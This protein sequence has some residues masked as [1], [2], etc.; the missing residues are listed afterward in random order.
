MENKVTKELAQTFFSSLP[1]E[2]ILE[3]ARSVQKRIMSGDK[4][5][6]KEKND[7]TIVTEADIRIEQMIIDCL[8]GSP[9]KDLCGIRGEENVGNIEKKGMWTLLMD[10][11]DGSS[12]LVKGKE[13][14]GVMIGLLDENGI[15]QYSWNLI[16]TGE[17]FGNAMADGSLV[18]AKL[19]QIKKPIIDFYDYSSGQGDFFRSELAKAG[20]KNSE[21]TSYPA[22]V[23]AGWKLFQNE[24]SALVWVM[25]ENEKKIYPDYDLIFLKALTEQGYKLR[26]GKLASNE[27][28]ILVVAPTDE[29]ADL[30]Y[31]AALDIVSKKSR[32]LITEIKNKLII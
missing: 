15:L 26:L 25:G 18:K 29:D 19:S 4:T 16:S 32:L 21:L 3:C 2:K 6:I 8:N 10:P 9:L 11:I 14:W 7:H 23:W 28:G 1:K 20:V 24:L 22:A 17:V 27:N 12:S 30:L 5:A 13:T 31:K